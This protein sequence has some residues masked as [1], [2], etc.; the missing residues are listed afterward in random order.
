MGD[1]VG[2]RQEVMGLDS[3][4]AYILNFHRGFRVLNFLAISRFE[5][6]N[7]LEAA[8]K[9]NIELETKKYGNL[10][11]RIWRCKGIPC[12]YL[13]QETY[14]NSSWIRPWTTSR[15]LGAAKKHVSKPGGRRN[16]STCRNK[17]FF[18][19]ISTSF[20]KV[21]H[22]RERPLKRV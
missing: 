15:F 2:W 4:S 10:F 20:L 8:R 11:L 5:F 16:F 17:R 1:A 21:D 7:K 19:E 6:V 22:P 13:Q 9:D 3:F 14:N 12:N 18:T